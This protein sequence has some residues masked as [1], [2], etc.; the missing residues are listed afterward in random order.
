MIGT[1]MGAV[2]ILV[3][4]CQVFSGDRTVNQYTSDA[5][6]TANVKAELLHESRVT[7]LPIHVDTDKGTVILSG[8][9]K[10]SEQKIAAG[11]AAAH[12]KGARIIRNNI[13]IRK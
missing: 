3:T 8:F 11:Q 1:T 12:A 9:V 5:A 7:S 13:V 2:L 6:V 4:G 10:N